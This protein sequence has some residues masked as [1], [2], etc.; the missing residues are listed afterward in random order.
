M[1]IENNPCA[2]T[3]VGVWVYQPNVA[4][5]LV[6]H[7]NAARGE[8]LTGPGPAF[9]INWGGISSLGQRS[10]STEV[11][12]SESPTLTG[13]WRVSRMRWSEGSLAPYSPATPSPRR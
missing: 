13:I 10:S 2:V 7:E 8:I 5:G 9:F 4:T 3:A 11:D 1:G 12:G 6:F